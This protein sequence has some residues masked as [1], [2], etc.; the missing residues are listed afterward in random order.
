MK[1]FFLISLF[2]VILLLSACTNTASTSGILVKEPWAR[3]ASAMMEAGESGEMTEGSMMSANGAAFMILENTGDAPDKLVSVTSDV[4]Q[5]VEIHKTEMQ[6]GIM[7]MA[8]VD[9]IEVPAKGNAELKPGGF[10]I[11]L[12]GLKKDLVPGEQIELTLNFEQAGH[13]TVKAEV[14]AP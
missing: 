11:M 5:T 14:R 8:P 3:A 6:E 1:R 2:V 7:R 4:A 12:I 10:H 9:F 13:I